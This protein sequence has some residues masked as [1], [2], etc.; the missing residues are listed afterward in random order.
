[1]EITIKRVCFTDDGVLGVMIFNNKPVCV[2][3]EEEWKDNKNSISC[4]PG[5]RSYLCQRYTRPSGMVT[6]QVLDVPGRTFILFHPG[7]TEIDTEGCILQGKE[8]GTVEAKD[9]DSGQKERQIAV[10]RSKEAFNDFMNL[11]NEKPTFL[12]HIKNC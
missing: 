4:I 8:F 1:M 9:D 12:L 6:Y 7:T 5:D 10:L 11:T 2:T 3:L